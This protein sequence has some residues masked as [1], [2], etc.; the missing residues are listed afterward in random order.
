MS[1]LLLEAAL[2]ALRGAYLLFVLIGAVVLAAVLSASLDVWR[3]ARTSGRCRSSKLPGI[4]GFVFGY[5]SYSR[6]LVVGV[7]TNLH[8]RF[9][10]HRVGI[11]NT[12]GCGDGPGS[13]RSTAQGGILLTWCVAD[14]GGER[15]KCRHYDPE[16]K[17]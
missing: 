16:R 9:Q 12:I 17:S 10:W 14:H 6:A 11:C 2:L 15:C 8:W 4:S 13:H 7:G 3:A 1:D 5:D